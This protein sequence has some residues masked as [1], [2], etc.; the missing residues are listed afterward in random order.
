[1]T[2]A[3]VCF[4][5]NSMWTQLNMQ[6]VLSAGDKKGHSLPH[7]SCHLPRCLEGSAHSLSTSSPS[8]TVSC[9]WDS[10]CHVVV[11]PR[12]SWTLTEVVSVSKPQASG[13]VAQ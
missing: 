9:A 8:A 13:T 4:H 1:M 3:N 10:A 6:I 5:E 11:L 2:V 7:T 12:P